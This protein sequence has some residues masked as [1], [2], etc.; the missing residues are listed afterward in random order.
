[1]FTYYSYFDKIGIILYYIKCLRYAFPTL[2]YGENFP[3]NKY[4]LKTWP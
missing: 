1:M 3:I 2:L 4:F